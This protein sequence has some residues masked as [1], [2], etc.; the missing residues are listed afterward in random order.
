[1]TTPAFLITIDTEEDNLWFSPRSRTTENARWLPRFQA[2]CERYGLKP[3]YL[4]NYGMATSPVF[5]SFARETLRREACEIG[6]HL[7]AWNT[8]PIRPLTDDD[9]L[10]HPYLI[11]YPAEAI[12]EKVR[13]M[14]RLLED[15]FERKMTSHR[16]G[17]WA[18]DG[19]YVRCLEE[20][21][22]AV[23]CSVTPGISWK[24]HLGKP[25]GEGGADY[26]GCPHEPYYLDVDDVRRPGHSGVLEVPVTIVAN[27][28]RAADWLR[29]KVRPSS[30][31]NVALNRWYP[32]VTWLRPNGWNRRG[33]LRV[34]ETA[35]AERRSFVEFMLHSSELMPGGS[36]TCRD[37]QSLDRLYRHIE[38]VFKVA[39]RSFRPAALT[40]FA[41]AVPAPPRAPEAARS[42]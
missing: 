40:E 35:R 26:T 4:T 25:G 3:T 42:E 19:R 18:I 9:D 31:I 14:T 1:M 36:G 30:R 23:D 32:A 16:A 37:E 21:G 13:Y 2:L 27:S 11:E 20:C 8:P 7:H 5:Q 38:S 28:P 39:S 24:E 6:M 12:G 41:A 33:M 29:A 22:Y 34:L 10:Y 17:R 15:V